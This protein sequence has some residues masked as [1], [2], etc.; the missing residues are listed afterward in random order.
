MR[1]M[2]GKERAMGMCVD[3]TKNSF[4]LFGGVNACILP[5]VYCA[6]YVYQKVWRMFWDKIVR[7]VILLVFI[8]TTIERYT[9]H[10][11]I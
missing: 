2:G 10:E 4:I 3:R 6:C 8:Q 9:V 5:C 11:I 1:L 7:M